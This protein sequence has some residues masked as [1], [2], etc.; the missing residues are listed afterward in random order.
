VSAPLVS[1]IVPCYNGRDY[2]SDAI[3][4]ALGQTYSPIEV[5]VVDDGSTDD[6]LEVIRAF[7]DR[8]KCLPMPHRGG[9]AA[10]NAGLEASRGDLIQFLDA[11]DLLDADKLRRQVDALLETGADMVFCDETRVSFIESQ[12]VDRFSPPYKGED[13]VAFVLEHSIPTILALHRKEKLLAIGGWRTD[14]P[15]AQEFDLH[16]RLACS[17]CALHHLPEVLCKG[18][19]VP[20]SV[21]SNYLGVLDQYSRILEPA[22]HGLKK[23]GKLDNERAQAFAAAMARAARHYLQHGETKKA[24][25][26][27]Q[28]ARTMHPDGGLPQVYSRPARLLRRIMGPVITERLAGFNRRHGTSRNPDADEPE[29]PGDASG[30]TSRFKALMILHGFPPAHHSGTFRNEAFA[31]HLPDFDIQPVVLCAT[32]DDRGIPYNKVDGWR[33]NPRW[34]EVRR[35]PWE[36]L[37]EPGQNQPAG[38]WLQRLPLGWTVACRLARKRVLNRVLPAAIELVRQHR[39]RVIYVSSPPIEAALVA[40]ALAQE[41]GLP[42]VCDLR[43]PWTFLSWARYRHWLDFAIERRIEHN[44]LSRAAA[45]IANTPTA[46]DLL[47]SQIRLPP[48]KVIVIPNGYNESDFK[49]LS[50]TESE[51]GSKFTVAYTGILSSF[52]TRAHSTRQ[53][54][55]HALAVDYQPVDSDPNTRS[56]RWFFEAVELLLDAE[57]RLRERL[58]IVFAGAYT[59]F[60][61]AIFNAFRYP[62]CLRVLPPLPHTEALRLCARANLCLL[63]QIEMRLGGKDY[64]TAI[65][66]KLY[67]YLRVGTRLLAPLQRGD[68]Q[69]LIEKFNA[70]VVV[71]PRDVQAIRAA[72]ERE[73]RRWES[74]ES[75]RRTSA[76]PELDMYERRRLTRRLAEVLRQAVQENAS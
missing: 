45:V 10:R 39:P 28:K 54:L 76:P 55:K 40:D 9:G 52:H 38:R 23:S 17:G 57:P 8:V 2:V 37:P 51:R 58:E 35:L 65:P 1:I 70:G 49:S 44:V 20:G 41:T 30:G 50:N 59:E 31:R 63:L 69:E 19:C 64:C 53:M 67:D 16:L 56:P 32:D 24:A 27:F 25:A 48:E 43:D 4:S 6:S 22:Y 7:G 33:D 14:I 73:I 74:G 60:D 11:D 21:S 68:A 46:R 66:G 15:C 61:R 13:P 18:R 75:S 12:Y 29:K 26:Y 71:P 72:L 42:L 47:I 36:L 62:A 3:R 34:A 5:I